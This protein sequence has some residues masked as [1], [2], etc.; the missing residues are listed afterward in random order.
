MN[1][2]K[3]NGAPIRPPNGVR[4][5]NNLTAQEGAYYGFEGLVCA[6]LVKLPE[7]LLLLLVHHNV[8]PGDGLA[9]DP[10]LA[11]LGGGSAGHLGNFE[12]GQLVLQVV[13]LLAQLLLLHLTELVALV[14]SL[15]EMAG[16]CSILYLMLIFDQIL[17]HFSGLTGGEGPKL[18]LIYFEN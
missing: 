11:E 12:G 16:N 14:A 9:H 18:P 5:L 15:K 2:L 6:Y 17:T 10:D 1:V 13:E 8:D 3:Y 4:I 7:V